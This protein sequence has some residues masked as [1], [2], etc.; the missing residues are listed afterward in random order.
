MTFSTKWADPEPKKPKKSIVTKAENTP[1]TK[2]ERGK[3]L[4]GVSGN[5]AG[6]P[7]GT[8]SIVAALKRRLSEVNPDEE[9]KKTYLETMIDVI[10]EKATKTKDVTMMRDIVNRVDGLPKQTIDIQADVTNQN[11]EASEE[12]KKA[13]REF[14]NWR[15]ENNK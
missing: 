11:E 14:V 3:W 12:V 1:I 15:K 7:A 8:I 10:I 2:N 13:V 4:P 9:D 6:K 5:P